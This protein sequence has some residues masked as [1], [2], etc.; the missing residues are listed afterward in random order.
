MSDANKVRRLDCARAKSLIHQRLDG[1]PLD[2]PTEAWLTGHVERCA[3]CQATQ[4]ELRRIHQALRE[5]PAVPLPDD[6]LAEVWSRTSRA[7]R[8]RFAAVWRAAAVAAVLALVFVGV[9]QV[10]RPRIEALQPTV[11][12]R[13]L[14][15]DELQRAALEARFV[16]NTAAAA[17]RKSEN[18]AFGEVLGRR[19]SPALKKVPIR[20]PA[21]DDTRSSDERSNGGNDV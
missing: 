10:T 16:L 2:R 13:Q 9:W 11:A 1:D 21:T 6:A 4:A 12:E 7:P 8:R 17:L 5:M 20:W 3:V 15:E 19:V 14:S 18:A